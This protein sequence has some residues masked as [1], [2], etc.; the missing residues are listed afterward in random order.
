MSLQNE[1]KKWRICC[2]YIS[3]TKCNAD[4]DVRYSSLS[5]KGKVKRLLHYYG[6]PHGESSLLN[7]RSL[8]AQRAA[9]L[10]RWHQLPP[11]T[12]HIGFAPLK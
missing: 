6:A 9:R 10:V 4:I 12:L 3:Q 7:S 5:D 2:A 11:A 1:E 8:A